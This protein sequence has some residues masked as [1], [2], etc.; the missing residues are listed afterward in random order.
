MANNTNDLG[1]QLINFA[2]AITPLPTEVPNKNRDTYT[3]W[4]E[5]N[6][7]PNFLL[8]LF[9]KSAIHKG[10]CTSKVDYIFGDG[11]VD[12]NGQN[13]GNIRVNPIDTLQEF[14]QKI[15][16][17][18]VIFNCFAVEIVYN[19]LN[20]PFQ[21]FHVPLNK[22]RPNDSINKFWVNSDWYTGNRNLL[23][24]DRYIVGNNENGGSKM[25][26]YKNYSPSVNNVFPE[27]DYSGAIESIVTDTLIN[28]FFQENISAGFSAG[29]II[30]T[31]KG[32]GSEETTRLLTR[33]FQESLSGANGLKFILD[34]NNAG[35]TPLS[36]QTIAPNDYA[37]KLVEVIKKTERNILAAHQG[38]SSLLFGIEKEGSLGNSSELENAYQLFKDGYVKNRR[39]ELEA[40]LNKLFSEFT[41]V[42][43]FKFKDKLRL[44]APV[45]SDATKEK[46]Y[47]INEL[48]V[49]AGLP[50]LADGDK[51]LTASPTPTAPNNFSKPEGAEV[52]QLSE[53]NFEEVKHLGTS[54][55]DF[56]I[57]N[58]YSAA[59]FSNQKQLDLQLDDDKDVA[60]YL[61]KA[62]LEG[63]SISD[64]RA[65]IKKE[66]SIS[67]T[68]D[69]LVKTL[70]ALTRAQVIDVVIDSDTIK[71]AVKQPKN[72]AERQV[73]VMYSYEKR[74][75]V[76]GDKIMPTSRAFCKKLCETEKL[77]SREDVQTM[78]SIFNYDVFTYCGGFYS[79][80]E[81]G[82]TVTTPYCRHYFKKVS[83]IR[84]GKK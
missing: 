66:L 18:Y 75:E 42:P 65:A 59:N 47:T 20:Q 48:R 53:E 6:L 70:N 57:I 43:K 63:K 1:F 51:L 56:E 82:K 30:S 39:N 29:H 46:I 21:F 83:V 84:K 9:N 40:G 8:K 4:G 81:G 3:K 80:Q 19:V 78:S 72:E 45:I 79:H 11:L 22:V 71:K 61:T 2:R 62:D 23:T 67:I 31:F 33:K 12:E 24:Y 15:T 28:E 50:K 73:E 5:D 58:E 77:Y 26:F 60:D 68:K 10:I 52:F 27:V 35:D 69:D 7:Y 32:I 34:L 38:T 16:N 76:D 13:I 64:V 44:F 74:P 14:I 49:E 55:A 17:D 41:A 54:K 36:V 37:T 25:F